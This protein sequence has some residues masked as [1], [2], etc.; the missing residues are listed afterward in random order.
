MQYVAKQ[1]SRQKPPFAALVFTLSSH[2]PYPIPPQHRGRFKKGT[3]E[4]HESIGYAD[5]ALEQFFAT[6]RQ[7]PWYSNT[8]FVLTG[9]HTQK[10]ETPEYSNPL[11]QH[12]V[13]L[14][15]FH[16]QK[17]FPLVDTHR[18]TQHVDIL[19]SV[20]DCLNIRPQQRLLFGSSVFQHGEG[21]AFFH[22]SGHYWLVRGDRAL[23]FSPENAGRLFDWSNDPQLKSPLLNEPDKLQAMER[24]AGALLQYFNN[25]LLDSQLYDP[26]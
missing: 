23:D 9:D 2:S 16:P 10:L 22:E 19:P 21:R 3:L 8:L 13:P 25:G 1:L 17:N 4:I 7:Q 11:G 24:E 12:R 20:L 14:L 5:Y 6:A 18:I 26:K 15:F